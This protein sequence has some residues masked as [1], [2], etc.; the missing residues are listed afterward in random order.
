LRTAAKLNLDQTDEKYTIAETTDPAINQINLTGLYNR[1]DAFL[2]AKA[3]SQITGATEKQL[4][5]IM[6]RFPGVSRRFEKIIDNLYSDYAHTPEKIVGCMSVAREMAAKNNQKIIAVYEPLT[7]RRMHYLA[8]AHRDAF[9][10]ASK[11]YWVPSFLAREDP[12]LP[13]LTPAELIKNLSPDMQSKAEPAQL[14]S[15][16]KAKLEQHLLA[17]D[18]VVA[19]GGGVTLDEWIRKEFTNG[20]A[21]S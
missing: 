5:D 13:V 20:T 7:N 19:M 2:V 1:R 17:G 18:L 16:L 15:T 12:A 11:L 8:T 14:D 4:L 21:A 3:V 9:A 6:N 10:G